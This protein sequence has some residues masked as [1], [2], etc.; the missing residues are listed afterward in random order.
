M[1]VTLQGEVG[2]PD[3]DVGVEVNRDNKLVVLHMLEFDSERVASLVQRLTFE[4]GVRFDDSLFEHVLNNP[5][6]G[7]VVDLAGRRHPTRLGHLADGQVT[8][9]LGDPDAAWF[10]S[11]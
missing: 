10:R 7:L 11:S 8:V 4:L 1:R 6:Y 9:Y 2:L 3:L 5:R